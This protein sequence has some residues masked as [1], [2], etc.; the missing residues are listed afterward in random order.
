[1]ATNA[2]DDV[3]DELVAL[4]RGPSGGIF[5]EG[6]AGCCV[7]LR[8]RTATRVSGRSPRS[9]QRENERGTDVEDEPRAGLCDDSLR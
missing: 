2:R 5:G 4:E 3:D 9:T 7:V 6:F 1:M 8:E